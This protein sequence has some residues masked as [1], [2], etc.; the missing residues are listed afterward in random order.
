MNVKLPY[1]VMG[2]EGFHKIKLSDQQLSTV[3]KSVFGCELLAWNELSDGWANSAYRLELGDQRQVVLKASPSDTTSLMRYELQLMRTE[4]QVMRLLQGIDGLP[5]PRIYHYD[6]SKSLLTVDYFIMEYIEGTPYN[7]VKES[8]QA[9]ERHAIELQ[10]GVMNRRINE[11]KGKLFGL[12]S[13][14]KHVS[15]KDAFRELIVGVL[16]DGRDAKVILPISYEELGREIESRLH[17]LDA[18]TDSQL[19]H[20][21]LWDG[22]VFVKDGKITG[23]ID[24]ERALWGDPLIEAYFGRFNPSPA[25]REGYG[26]F[27]TEPSQLARRA[28]YDLY[29]DLIMLIECTYRQYES[30]EHAQWAYDNFDSSLKRFLLPL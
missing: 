22:N 13:G 10:L 17:V 23:I 29:L 7:K 1:E 25:F 9:P 14:E 6:D 20:W 4:V 8:V 12:Y 19:V 24:F 15:W 2:L 28:L 26:L 30:K 5:V 11:V 21:D 16:E 3:V 27:L 18:V